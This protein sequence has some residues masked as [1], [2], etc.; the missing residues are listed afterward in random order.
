MKSTTS[1]LEVVGF[2]LKLT[3]YL[4]IITYQLQA[5]RIAF[6]EPLFSFQ[7]TFQKISSQ[8]DETKSWQ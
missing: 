7:R 4:L 5:F 1:P 6:T 2:Y 8:N 3:L